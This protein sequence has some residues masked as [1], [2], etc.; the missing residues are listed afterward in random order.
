MPIF[1]TCRNAFKA[2]C[3][4]VSILFVYP[5]SGYC[6]TENPILI[7]QENNAGTYAA[8]TAR[9]HVLFRQAA[10]CYRSSA[11]SAAN[12]YLQAKQWSISCGYAEGVA[13]A[14]MGLGNCS[15][16]R[17]NY[18]R[19]VSFYREA[20]PFCDI[21]SYRNKKIMA[22]WCKDFAGF[23][24]RMGQNDSSVRYLIKAAETAAVLKDT[25]LLININ[26]NLGAVWI[27][28]NQADNAIYYLRKA[29][30]LFLSKA[31]KTRKDSAL[32]PLVYN[33]FSAAYG[34]LHDS[35]QALAYAEKCLAISTL[36]A[37]HEGYR[38]AL[39]QLAGYYINAVQPAKAAAYYRQALALP[40]DNN[41]N[42]TH[43]YLVWGLSTACLELGQFSD[44]I[45]YGTEAL[46]IAQKSHV[47]DATR[48]QL[49]HFLA[50]VSDSIGNY[51]QA[52]RYQAI[53][54]N[55]NDSI[56]NIERDKALNKLE[57]KFRLSEKDKEI[58]QK[59]LLY[60]KKE[61]SLR[62]RNTWIAVIA[63]SAL[64]AAGL[65]IVLYRSVRRRIYMM[66]QQEEIKELKA[67][68]TGEEKERTRL[69]RELHDG[70]GGLLS[71]A[72]INLHT[73]GDEN[74]EIMQ[75]PVYHKTEMLIE[76]ISKEVRKTAH[77]LMPDTLLL[78]NLPE[79]VR[80]YC[81]YM[82]QGKNL[83]IEVRDFGNFDSLKQDFVLSLYRIIQELIQNI[84]KHAHASSVFIQLHADET[85]LSITVEDNGT[86]F[87][88]EAVSDGIGL[89]NITARVAAL[90]GRISLDTEPGKGTSV[91]IEFDRT[92]D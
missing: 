78:H 24:N 70:I 76:E 16:L 21:A 61:N 27:G 75:H 19:A 38:G 63:V 7:L 30:Q 91:Y 10:S 36:T 44:A 60:T 37:D 92:E 33:N 41:L 87:N 86:G 56:T 3:I 73:L 49:Y 18:T 2:C 84:L 11:D 25:T 71:A 55:I 43:F 28:N 74:R 67:I 13:N 58:A 50:T 8:D 80:L 34:A 52:Y 88:K 29:E 89:N 64:L 85:L 1:L 26:S 4:V 35:T 79:A 69:A 31:G 66:Q 15:A 23:Y 59:Q 12:L 39:I 53:S 32:L 5:F 57:M 65:L 62:T 47:N 6:Q 45:R 20:Y 40:D 77:N 83:Q 46:D 22:I 51:R 42:A 72:A 90:R 54:S 68:M 81:S 14:L 9:I 82:R 48:A 17:G